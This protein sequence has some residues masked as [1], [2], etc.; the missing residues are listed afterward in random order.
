MSKA[1][2]N[3]QKALVLDEIGKL[4]PSEQID[5]YNQT[6]QSLGLNPLTRPLGFFNL[7]GK[8]TLYAKKDATDQ[9]RFIHKISVLKL[10]IRE[11]EFSYEVIAY[12]RNGEGREDS[13][14]GVVDITNLK[15]EK[16]ANAKL[17]AVTKAKRRLT[18]SLCGLG[19]LDETE[20]ET[21]KDAKPVDITKIDP[22]L[23][24]PQDDTFGGEVPNHAPQTQQEA[25]NYTK[26]IKKIIEKKT[27]RAYAHK[28]SLPAPFDDDASDPGAH[29]IGG[30]VHEGKRIDSFTIHDLDSLFQ[31]HAEI[32]ETSGRPAVPWIVA[33]MSS[34]ERYLNE[35]E[36]KK[37]I[38]NVK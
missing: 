29:V 33:F 5:L 24:A 20:V 18:L 14:L 38:A 26:P 37:E 23:D 16:L 9:L 6:C 21:I 10:E 28:F 7:N 19:L 35:R 15:G 27:D 34:A 36:I 32:R 13:D 4:T 1:V 30:G 31:W 8:Y 11:T 3:I 22:K 12:G 2:T 25:K 17:K